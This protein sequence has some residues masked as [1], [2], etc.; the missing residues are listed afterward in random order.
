[1][2][3]NIIIKAR[4]PAKLPP[5][6]YGFDTS[7]GSVLGFHTYSELPVLMVRMINMIILA[8]LQSTEWSFCEILN[9][10]SC[11]IFKTCRSIQVNSLLEKI[12]K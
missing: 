6:A 11:V 12:S 2:L 8:V 9:S 7:P 10:M 1:M 5:R 3:G 4:P